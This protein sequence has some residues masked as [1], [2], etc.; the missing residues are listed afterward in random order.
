M[1]YRFS[2]ELEWMGMVYIVL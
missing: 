1:L 2:V